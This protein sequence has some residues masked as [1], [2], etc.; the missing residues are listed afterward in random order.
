VIFKKALKSTGAYEDWSIF[1]EKCT[2]ALASSA[3][4]VIA[5][6]NIKNEKAHS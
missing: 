4:K 1:T 5:Y 6:F 3:I 2:P